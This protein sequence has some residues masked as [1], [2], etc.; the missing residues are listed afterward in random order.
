VRLERHTDLSEALEG[1]KISER[2]F[3]LAKYIIF[4]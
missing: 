4:L 2:D 3:N 1:W